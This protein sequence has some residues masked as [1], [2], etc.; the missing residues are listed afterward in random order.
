MTCPFAICADTLE[1]FQYY[2]ISNN[3]GNCYNS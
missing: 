1:V 3:F 2:N